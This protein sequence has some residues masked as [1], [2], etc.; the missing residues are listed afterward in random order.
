MPIERL[1]LIK[2]AGKDATVIGPDIQI[3]QT[4][5]EFYGIANDWSLVNVLESTKGKVRYS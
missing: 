4:A 3:G 1:G 2:L 5:P